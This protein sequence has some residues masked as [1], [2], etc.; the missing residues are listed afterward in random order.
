[1]ASNLCTKPSRIP[2]TRDSEPRQAARLGSYHKRRLRVP[3][4]LLPLGLRLVLGLVLELVLGPVLL[5][6][7]LVLVL[8][9]VVPD[10]L[11]PL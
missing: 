2:C 4:L 3:L 5:V 6:L 8:V 9:V 1:V 11:F 7:V 10:L